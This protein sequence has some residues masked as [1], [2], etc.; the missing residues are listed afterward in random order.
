M[1]QTEDSLISPEYLEQQREMFQMHPTYG[2][3]AKKWAEMVAQ[4]ATAIGPEC[5]ILDYGCGRELLQELLPQFI[6]D[7]YDPA[8][9]D[10]TERP[11][12]H[13]L[14][15]C[16]DVLEHIEPHKLESV[17]NDLERVTGKVLLM[18][19]ATIPSVKLLPDGRNAHLIVKPLEWWLPKIWRRWAIDSV[20]R[21]DKGVNLMVTCSLR[22]HQ[23]LREEATLEKIKQAQDRYRTKLESGEYHE[24][25][26]RL[27][28]K[29]YLKIR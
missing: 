1:P 13:D 7:G 29:E 18:N 27:S 10:R 3:A 4:L 5:T 8:I 22:E 11:E 21:D 16:L 23:K 19:I 6:V 17:L 9:E 26:T 12:R 15:V 20:L 28:E 25:A 14:V 2:T 24:M